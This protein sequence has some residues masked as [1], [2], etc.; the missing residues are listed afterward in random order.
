VKENGGRYQAS[1]MKRRHENQILS[2][3]ERQAAARRAKGEMA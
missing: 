2:I 1:T 3:I